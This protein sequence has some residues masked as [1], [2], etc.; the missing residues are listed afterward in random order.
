MYSLDKV[1]EV[2]TVAGE[3]RGERWRESG[4]PW[5][6]WSVDKDGVRVRALEVANDVS[7]QHTADGENQ[8]IEVNGMLSSTTKRSYKGLTR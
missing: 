8:D 1:V 5:V 4:L 2:T 6:G 3:I 7:S